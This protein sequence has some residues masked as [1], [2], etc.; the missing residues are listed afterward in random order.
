MGSLSA[1]WAYVCVKMGMNQL[2]T[3][4]N[5]VAPWQTANEDVFANIPAPMPNMAER[6]IFTRAIIQDSLTYHQETVRNGKRNM[7]EELP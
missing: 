4:L 5:I 6:Y 3:E 7:T 1:T 2:N